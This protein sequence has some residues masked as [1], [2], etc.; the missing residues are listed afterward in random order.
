M[1]KNT[2]LNTAIIQVRKNNDNIFSDQNLPVI[3][4]QDS[5]LTS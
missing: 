5:Q 4:K 1:A 3:T 2:L